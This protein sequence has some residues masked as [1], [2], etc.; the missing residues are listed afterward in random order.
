MVT[1]GIYM[2]VRM[3]FVYILAPETMHLVAWI[4]AVTALFAAT[5]GVTQNDIKKVLAYSTVSQLGIMF[6][7]LG[8]G[9]FT[10]GVFH[11][12]THAFFKAC[13]FLGAGSVIH[14]LGGE[15]DI[16]KMGGLRKSMPLTYWTFLISA[17]AISGIVPLSGFF[18]KDEILAAVF[19]HDKILWAISSLASMLT[20]F[21]MFRLVFLTF[22]GEF[23]GTE[24]QKHHLHESPALITLPLVVLALLAAVGGLLG[25][26]EAFGF[27]HA[28]KG[29]LAPV[30]EMAMRTNPAE[31]SE[32][33]KSTEL[34][35]MGLALLLAIIAIGYAYKKY[36]SDK[37]VP[38]PDSHY[39]TLGRLVYNKYYVDEIYSMLFV[40]PVMFL[41]D[42]FYS[43]VDRTLVDGIITRGAKAS[44]VLGNQMRRLQSGY[45]GFYLLAMVLS[46]VVMFLYAFIIK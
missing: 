45:I 3:H 8:V 4:G 24:E 15:Q 22:T 23:R 40:S 34:A 6:V 19:E 1:A 46:I 17:L 42:I 10:S 37:S 21:Y 36:V 2:L 44:L 43:L 30:F 38:T 12:I 18:S 35:L 7:A 41:S 26:P 28:L 16:R 27:H 32:T 31:A 29:F 20:A 14:A 5:I 9:A 33:S 25:L 13:L 11:V 39:G